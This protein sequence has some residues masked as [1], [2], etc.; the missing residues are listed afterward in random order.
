MREL[1]KNELPIV[2]KNMIK[3]QEKKFRKFSV[4]EKRLSKNGK[5]EAKRPYK[6]KNQMQKADRFL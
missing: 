2:N 4:K 5:N 6:Q 3:K 1:E